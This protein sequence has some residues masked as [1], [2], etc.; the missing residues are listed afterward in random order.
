M[1]HRRPCI[2]IDGPVGAGK[3]TIARLVAQGLG[4]TYIDSGAMYRALA[5]AARRDGIGADDQTRVSELVEEVRIRI[6]PRADGLN[7]VIVDGDDIT[8]EIRSPEISQL[9]SRLSAMPPVRRRMVALQQ[10]MA[11]EGG[12]VMEGRDIQTVVLPEAEVKIFLTASAEERARR[13]WE[14]LRG[15]GRE[16]DLQHVL[17]DIEA[18]DARDTTRADSPLKP[19][20]DAVHVDTDGLTIEQVVAKVLAIAKERGSA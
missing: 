16:A 13:R 20:P 19:A 4:Y 11:R 3:S 7:Q 12:V 10:D 8:S 2:A 9:A 17:A 5:W 1:S 6:R 15:R 18:R 14:E